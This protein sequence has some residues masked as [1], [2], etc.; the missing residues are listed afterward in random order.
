MKI[1]MSTILIAVL[2][3]GC[4]TQTGVHTVDIEKE[5]TAVQAVLDQY[6]TSIENEDMELYGKI[7]AHDI[8]MINF[9]AFGEPVKG[10]EGVKQVIEEQNESLSGTKIEQNFVNIHVLP[11]GQYAWATSI[12]KLQT[13]MGEQYLNLPVRCTW[14]LEKSGNNWVIVHWHKSIAAG[15][16]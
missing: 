10:W 8:S 16:G 3:F 7:M 4:Q 15:A 9:G 6:I 1:L 12:W 13:N 14:I 2:L 11:P 5:K